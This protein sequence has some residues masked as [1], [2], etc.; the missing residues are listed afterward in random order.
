MEVNVQ[1][2]KNYCVSCKNACTVKDANGGPLLTLAAGKQDYFKATTPTVVV[3]DATATVQ[4]S[5]ARA[6]AAFCAD[7]ADAA[8]ARAQEAAQLAVQTVEPFTGHLGDG[9]SHV[10]ANGRNVLVGFDLEQIEFY[11]GTTTVAIGSSYS[12]TSNNVTVGIRAGRRDPDDCDIT[13][14][15][16]GNRCGSNS[17]SVGSNA[18]CGN[19]TVNIGADAMS[20][21]NQSVVIGFDAASDGEGGVSIGAFA[22]AGYQDSIAVGRS[23]V[24]NFMESVAIGTDAKCSGMGISIGAST[25]NLDEGCTIG[26]YAL[27][28]APGCVVI[29][30]SAYSDIQNGVAIGYCAA[31]EHDDN[32]ADSGIA[33][34]NSAYSNNT[35]ISIGLC[36][37]SL[38]KSIAIGTEA[39]TGGSNSVAIG[40]YAG[41]S[42]GSIAIGTEALNMGYDSVAIGSYA[43][44][45]E[46]SVVLGDSSIGE[47]GSVS[48]GYG[49]VAGATSCIAI[50]E[51]AKAG[52]RGEGPCSIALGGCASAIGE[53]G[54][55]IGDGAIADVANALAIGWQSTSQGGIAIGKFATAKEKEI[56]FKTGGMQFLVC[57]EGSEKAQQYAGGEACMVF[58]CVDTAGNPVM[59]RAAKI[60]DLFPID[61]LAMAA[62]T[63]ATMGL[64]GRAVEGEEAEANN[65]F[66]EAVLSLVTE[67]DVET[68]RAEAKAAAE[69]RAEERK[70]E[71]AARSEERKA[72]AAVRI[73][74]R[75]AEMA[76]RA[77]ARKAEREAAAAV[78]AEERKAAAAARRAELEKE[79]AELDNELN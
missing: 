77:E 21:E 9:L 41:G 50:G 68:A 16:Y 19:N 76:A 26:S 49:S 4:L 34:G 63:P 7:A 45:Y 29:G 65:A 17:V 12:N 53:Y 66:V 14:V 10:Y 28:E 64:R 43:Q 32:I 27:G 54:I 6:D 15:G 3:S 70:A 72:A 40:S 25:G 58:S 2:G 71:V 39:F 73:E 5:T 59:A 60:A 22:V 24:S 62:S 42:Q 36:T 11:T 69:A 44:G 48:I 37:E 55:A 23:A 30:S 33:I 74:E 8:A 75:K 57:G 35:G 20:T 18:S 38:D 31:A 13:C 46:Y 61:L 78:Y 51:D 79:L 67:P 47:S 56:V 1:A 52:G